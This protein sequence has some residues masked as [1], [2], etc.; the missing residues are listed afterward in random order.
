MIPL[1]A[2]ALSG[3]LALSPASD[4][5]RARDLAAAFPQWTSLAADTA[6]LPAPVPG[7]QRVLHPAELRRLALHWNVP[8][9]DRPGADICFTI[10]VTPPDPARVLAAMQR[11]APDARIEILETS[12]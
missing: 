8:F 11:R 10:P 4:Q 12:R 3:C 2:F 9:D 6:L 1:A 7:V 5:I